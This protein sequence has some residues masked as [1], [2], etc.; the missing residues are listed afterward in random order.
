MAAANHLAKV[1]V[2]FVVVEA[3]NHTGGRTHAFKQA[4]L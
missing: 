1:G 2:S 4:F 3:Q